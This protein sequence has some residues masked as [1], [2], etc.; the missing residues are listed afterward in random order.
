MPCTE[1]GKSSSECS[2]GTSNLRITAVDWGDFSRS[3]PTRSKAEA[4]PLWREPEQA[5]LD[6]PGE[7]GALGCPDPQYLQE[8]KQDVTRLFTMV[9]E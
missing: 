1:E 5:G 3:L 6:Q 9:I 7:E 2:F 8:D 4:V